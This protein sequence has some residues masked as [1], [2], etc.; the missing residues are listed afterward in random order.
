[1]PK[2]GGN[3]KAKVHEKDLDLE[4][5]PRMEIINGD[6]KSIRGGEMEFQWGQM[7]H[8]IKDQTVPDAGVE[9]ILLYVNIRKSRYSS[10]IH[11]KKIV[12]MMS[13]VKE[14]YLDF[15]RLYRNLSRYSSKLSSSC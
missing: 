15:C 6:T 7:Y 4:V 9:D 1:M 2:K 13:E 10:W 12:L 5:F 11:F 3:K 14:V 8:M